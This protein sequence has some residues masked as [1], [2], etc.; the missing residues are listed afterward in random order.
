MQVSQVSSPRSEHVAYQQAV[1]LYLSGGSGISARMKHFDLSSSEKK[2]LSARILLKKQNTCE[3]LS[4]LSHPVPGDGFLEAE[5]LFLLGTAYFLRADFENALKLNLTAAEKYRRLGDRRGQF[6]SLYNAS[7]DASKMN[8]FTMCQFYL[9]SAEAHITQPDEKILA[10][11]AWACLESDRGDYAKS[12]S[13]IKNA[14]EEK[15]NL[16]LQDRL[17]FDH[18][19]SYVYFRSNKLE[20]SR[21]VLQTLRK[22]TKNRDRAL[23]EL[24]YQIVNFLLTGAKLPK[25]PRVTNRCLETTAKWRLLLLLQH[26]SLSEAKTQ[27][28][29]LCKLQPMNFAAEFRF[30]S[31]SDKQSPFARAVARFFEKNSQ[32]NR[33]TTNLTPKLELTRNILMQQKIPLRKEELIEQ[34]WGVPYDPAYDTRFYKM[35]ERLRKHGFRLVVRNQTYSVG[36]F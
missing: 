3:V 9:E 31:D 2:L 12:V 30:V 10:L 16:S 25:A 19:L 11:R 18:V 35:M 17:V 1:R 26:G 21:N 28:D 33:I 5:R 20:Q 32:P 34:I 24:D 36:R 13:L 7:V 8:L 15:T 4:L 14:M 6:L 22:K 27:W 23:V 29:L